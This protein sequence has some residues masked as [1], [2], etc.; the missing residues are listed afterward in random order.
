VFSAQNKRKILS[1]KS[2]QIF[3]W[4]KNVIRWLTFLKTNKHKKIWKVIFYFLENKQILI[5]SMI[6]L[7]IKNKKKLDKLKKN[8]NYREK[9]QVRNLDT[10]WANFEGITWRTHFMCPLG[11]PF[12]IL[13]RSGHV[14]F[15]RKTNIQ[16]KLHEYVFFFNF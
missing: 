7:Q 9:L 3:L 10:W 16:T 11:E 8:E 5:I 6:L 1:W 4:S 13:F 15:N 12:N 14:F 2:S